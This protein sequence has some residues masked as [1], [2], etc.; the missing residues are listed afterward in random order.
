M[1]VK[2]LP[3]A[4]NVTT[5]SGLVT[6]NCFRT[7]NSSSTNFDVLL[8]ISGDKCFNF[9]SNMVSLIKPNEEVLMLDA[10][11]VVRGCFYNS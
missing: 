7:K 5:F 11:V 2:I 1:E 8:K 6:G 10:S 4:I 9:S 3:E